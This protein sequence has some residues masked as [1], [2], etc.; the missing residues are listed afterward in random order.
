MQNLNAFAITW[1]NLQLK[2]KFQYFGH[3]MQRADSLEKT[4]M[5]GR[6]EGRRR[7]DNRGWD[8]WMASP[9][10]WTWLWVDS[11][12]WWWTGRPGVLQSMGWQR[13]G[14]ECVNELNWTELPHYR[15]LLYHLSHQAGSALSPENSLAASSFVILGPKLL[16]E[17]SGYP[18]PCS[19]KPNYWVLRRTCLLCF[20][21][22]RLDT[23]CYAAIGH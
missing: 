22:Q 19:T 10:Q 13:V 14:H 1:V 12:S 3:L 6:I 9:T 5:L 4:L 2:L 16:C 7:G 21:P 18:A 8:G 15:Q 17:K 11:R 20:K 23:A